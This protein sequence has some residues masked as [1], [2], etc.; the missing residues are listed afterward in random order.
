MAFPLCCRRSD[1]SASFGGGRI[2]PSE[3]CLRVLYGGSFMC[4]IPQPSL[5]SFLLGDRLSEGVIDF[6][7]VGPSSALLLSSVCCPSRNNSGSSSASPPGRSLR[8]MRCSVVSL[9]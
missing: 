3:S 2:A 9:L 6:C 7:L 5:R 4:C 8:S 1:W